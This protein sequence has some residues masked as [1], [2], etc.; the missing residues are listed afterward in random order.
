MASG[1]SSSALTAAYQL[2]ISNSRVWTKSL[3]A[4]LSV[5]LPQNACHSCTLELTSAFTLFKQ[6]V[7]AYLLKLAQNLLNEL[8]FSCRFSL[9]RYSLALKVPVAT[10]VRTMHVHGS[11]CIAV[12]HCRY[13]AS[14]GGCSKYK[15][16]TFCPL[17]YFIWAYGALLNALPLPAC[18]YVLFTIARHYT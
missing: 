6:V 8:F 14:L 18:S 9:L 12:N 1:S 17:Y 13:V 5:Q 7:Q 3:K 4:S 16:S 15:L 10:T 2:Y 11:L